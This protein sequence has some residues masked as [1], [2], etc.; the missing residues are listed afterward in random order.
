MKFAHVNI[1]TLIGHYTDM[2]VL[3]DEAKV[4]VFAVTESAQYSTIRY[5]RLDMLV[6]GRIEMEIEV[7]S[8]SISILPV[9][10]CCIG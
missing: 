10:M 3:L 2:E 6:T 8:I 9:T 4:D 1:A 7:N 5:V